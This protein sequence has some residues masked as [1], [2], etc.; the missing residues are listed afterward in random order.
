MIR[1]D[2]QTVD[3]RARLANE[4][5]LALARR[6][7]A[8]DTPPVELARLAGHHSFAVRAA[9]AAH[10]SCPRETLESLADDA[11]LAVRSAVRRRTAWLP[12]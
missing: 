2:R 7:A 9:V 11:S 6:A 10:P 5:W 1:D 4:R 8:P 12:G 3:V